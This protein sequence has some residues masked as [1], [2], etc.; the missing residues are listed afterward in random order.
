MNQF[1]K[2][3]E[4]QDDLP[5]PVVER[6]LAFEQGAGSSQRVH[7]DTPADATLGDA[8]ACV[9]LL[10]RVWPDID[11]PSLTADEPP[12]PKTLGDFRILRELGRGG[13]GTVFEAEQLS[14]GRRVALKVLPFAALVQER[15]LQRFRN[16]VRAAAALDHPH[17]V[18]VYS[19]GEDRGVHF[20]AMQ[21]IRGRTLGDLIGELRNELRSVNVVGLADSTHPTISADVARSGDRPQHATRPTTPPVGD[22]FETK[23]LEQARQSTVVDSG[24]EAGSFRMAAQ[25]GIQAA[26]ALQHAHDQGVLHRDIK[27]SNLLLDAQGKLYVTDFGLARIEADAGMTMTGDILG[28]LRYMAPEQALAKRVVIDHRADIYSLG[29]TLYELLTLEPAFGETDR[30]ELLKQI[31]FED[32]RPLRKIDRHIPAELE[33]IV[34]KAMA[35]HREE[36]YQTAQQLADDLRAYCEFRPI[37]ARPASYGDRLRKWSRRHQPLVT[38]AALALILLSGILAVSIAF[39]KRAQNQTVA[40]L[41]DT[42]DLLYITDMALAYQTLDKGWSDEVQTILD[43]HRPTGREPDRRGFEWHLLQMLVRP[44]DSITLAGHAG[45]VNELAVFPDRRRVA[46][47]GDD[48]TLRIWDVTAG[49]LL[50]AIPI[51]REGLKS[52]AVSADGRYVAAGSTS[53]FLCDLESNYE[54]STIYHNEHTIE[55]VAFTP[56]GKHLAAGSRY[57]HVAL[58]ARDGQLIKRI[59]CGARVESLEFVPGTSELIVPNRRPV[60]NQRPAGI[61]ELW[62]EELSAVEQV[63]D[64]SHDER[65]SQITVARSSPC[66]RF[67]AAGELRRSQIFVFERSTGRMIAESPASRDQLTDLAYSPE[68]T[69]IAAGY[70]NGH[71]EYFRVTLDVHGNPSLNRRP[72]VIN[73][74]RGEVTCTRFLSDRSLLSCGTDGLIRIW[75]VLG[76][77]A[78]TFQLTDQEM[79]GLEL[80]PDGALLLYV[81]PP[82]IVLMDMDRGEVVFRSSSPEAHYYKPAWAPKGD[83]AAVCSEHTQ[84]VT[85]LD[86]TGQ[87]IYSIAHGARPEAAA[88]SPDGSLVA[89]VGAQVLQLCHGMDGREILRRP[90][91][92]KPSTVTFSHD[93]RRLACGGQEAANMVFD[94]AT[95]KPIHRLAVGGHVSRLAFSPDDSILASGHEDSVIRLWEA[96]TGLLRAELAGHE[97]EVTRLEFSPDGRTLLSSAADGTVRVWSVDHGRAFGVFHRRFEVGSSQARCDLSL[98]SDGRRLVVG[99][100][101]Q[102]TDC[103][104]VFLWQLDSVAEN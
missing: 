59:P 51:C 18:S 10:H 79:V 21:L 95:M 53:V 86:R 20:Y 50:R 72:L 30:S 87:T 23:R 81:C 88:F 39:V 82:E 32:P 12:P 62:G 104:D 52:V 41:E 4:S 9:E 11:P 46:S 22:G 76:D 101:T 97:R 29:A 58:I 69:A 14:M 42:S 68:G 8:L 49:R 67:V 103:P 84:S 13:M 83:R 93:G 25:L 38:V 31:A 36:R 35:K 44:P 1:D 64:A 94:V 17:I 74:H 6:L 28:T 75:D 77:A 15:S 90:L 73:A 7:G 85:V 96:K 56:D 71:I 92:A 43:R 16:E 57:D 61:V 63:L 37:K 19:V 26:E 66:G 91:A 48:G 60:P 5:P 27:P 47:V 54:V 55:S 100:Q 78:Q 3:G 89:V 80:S 45:P 99:H 34:L 2:L 33:T 70:Q 24:R 98:S 65:D 102:L 40:A